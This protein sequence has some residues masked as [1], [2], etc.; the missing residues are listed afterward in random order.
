MSSNFVIPEMIL[1]PRSKILQII[2]GELLSIPDISTLNPL[3]LI[4]GMRSLN[5]ILGAGVQSPSSLPQL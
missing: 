5:M 3:D 4:K 1:S 2:K